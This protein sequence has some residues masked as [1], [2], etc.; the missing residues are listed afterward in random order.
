MTPVKTVEVAVAEVEAMLLDS[1]KDKPEGAEVSIELW[2]LDS[3]GPRVAEISNRVGNSG[4]SAMQVYPEG[5]MLCAL[6]ERCILER[7][8]PDLG[9]QEV[10]DEQLIEKFWE[11]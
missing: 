2:G 9:Y 11:N 1:W 7:M 5:L 6:A 10:Y 4:A 3:Q 8:Y